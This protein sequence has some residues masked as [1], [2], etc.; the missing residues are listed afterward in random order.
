VK[1]YGTRTGRIK[2]IH[3]DQIRFLSPYADRQ[4]LHHVRSVFHWPMEEIDGLA[5]TVFNRIGRIPQKKPLVFL[6]YFFKTA[7]L[8]SGP[9]FQPVLKIV[10]KKIVDVHSTIR[11]RHNRSATARNHCPGV[12]AEKSLPNSD[13]SGGFPE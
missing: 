10:R 13:A 8:R 12:E 7:P 4:A 3:T 1:K 6:P 2:R 5:R 9:L 11:I